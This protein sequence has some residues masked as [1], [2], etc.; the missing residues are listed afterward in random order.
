M[1]QW[2]LDPQRA[3]T[4]HADRR[5]IHDPVRRGL[6]HR[7]GSTLHRRNQRPFVSDEAR[8]ER[9][10]GGATRLATVRTLQMGSSCT[11]PLQVNADTSEDNDFAIVE[12]PEIEPAATIVH[13]GSMDNVMP[14]I[15]KTLARWIDASGCRSAG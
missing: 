12:L 9:R 15:Q 5:G 1:A 13:R 8:S 6:L 14:T 2:L 4:S 7:M 10:T 11:L 3:P